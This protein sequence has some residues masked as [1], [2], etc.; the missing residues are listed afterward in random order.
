MDVLSQLLHETKMIRILDQTTD[1]IL[2]S[3]FIDWLHEV[4]KYLCTSMF[5]KDYPLKHKHKVT[6]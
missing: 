4:K 1:A 6:I 2:F 5:P 3:T